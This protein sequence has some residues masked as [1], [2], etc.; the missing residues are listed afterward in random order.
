[1]L[2]EWI[3]WW[4]CLSIDEASALQVAKL[5]NL[6]NDPFDQGH[7]SVSDA[8]GRRSPK[9]DHDHFEAQ[10]I[11]NR[12]AVAGISSPHADLDPGQRRSLSRQSA[13]RLL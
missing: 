4:N 12:N 8:V 7:R 5:P 6:H 11:E 1:V 9:V 10:G 2:R 3:H 13:R